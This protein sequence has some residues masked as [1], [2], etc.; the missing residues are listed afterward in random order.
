M[1]LLEAFREALSSVEER[2][3]F[4]EMADVLTVKEDRA[5]K[6][7]EKL[8]EQWRALVEHVVAVP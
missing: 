3:R 8:R 1:C 5:W 2:R 6:E 7:V 4:V